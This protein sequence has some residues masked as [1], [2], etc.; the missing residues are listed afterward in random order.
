MKLLKLLLAASLALGVMT[1]TA[2]A[3]ATKG[4]KIFIKKFKSKCGFNGAKFA[5]KH[6]Q[7]EWEQI[8]SDGQFKDEMIKICPDVKPEDVKDKWIQHIYDFSYEYAVDSGN[9]PSC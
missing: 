2:S 9:V 1:T 8:M 5:A 3:D 7:A 4:Q 6:T